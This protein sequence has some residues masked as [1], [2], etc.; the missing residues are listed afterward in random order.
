MVLAIDMDGT[1]MKQYKVVRG[2]LDFSGVAGRTRSRSKY[3]GES[4]RHMNWSTH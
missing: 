4:S 1:L 3:G 2:A